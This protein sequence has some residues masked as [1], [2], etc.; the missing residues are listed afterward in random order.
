M[1]VDDIPTQ[2]LIARILEEELNLWASALNAGQIQLEEVLIGSTQD[3]AESNILDSTPDLK[4][5]P[6]DDADLALAL[7][8]ADVR[9]TSDAAYAESLQVSQETLFAENRQYA[10]SV[11]AAEKKLR[12]DMAYLY[13]LGESDVETQYLLVSVFQPETCPSRNQC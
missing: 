4:P 8:S 2:L 1:E 7:F 3:F 5:P 12:L 10:L 6:I 11:A 9:L 13:D